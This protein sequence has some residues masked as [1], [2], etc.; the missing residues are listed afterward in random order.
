LKNKITTS[1]YLYFLGVF[2]GKY[3]VWLVKVQLNGGA[4]D[5]IT[6]DPR[7]HLAETLL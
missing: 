3:L 2:K 6:S 4:L 5:S 1:G 7:I